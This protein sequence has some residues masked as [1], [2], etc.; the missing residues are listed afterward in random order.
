MK[1]KKAFH[2]FG[3]YYMLGEKVPPVQVEDVAICLD[4]PLDNPIEM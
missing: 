3:V 1:Q 2:W 4:K